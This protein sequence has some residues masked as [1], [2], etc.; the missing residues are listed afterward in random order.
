VFCLLSA[1]F[2]ARPRSFNLLLLFA[3]YFCHHSS[4]FYGLIN[5]DN[6]MLKYQ[7]QSGNLYTDAFIFLLF[8]VPLYIHEKSRTMLI[9]VHQFAAISMCDLCSG[10]SLWW[11]GLV[12]A[13]NLVDDVEGMER[14]F[15]MYFDCFRS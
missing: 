3:A 7:K 4:M 13:G 15:M 8:K 11:F 6:W 9:L 12:L 10:I 1:L 14:W 2:S 5:L